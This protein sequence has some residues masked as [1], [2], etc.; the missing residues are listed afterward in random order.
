MTPEDPEEEPDY[1]VRTPG[2]LAA[3]LLRLD[4]EAE[5]LK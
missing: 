1:T 2:E 4:A 3:L 5:A